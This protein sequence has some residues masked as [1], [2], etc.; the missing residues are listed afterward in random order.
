VTSGYT[1]SSPVTV[2]QVS[3]PISVKRSIV[4][5]RSPK[6]NL[7][8]NEK[9]S[10]AWDQFKEALETN[11]ST[12]QE[13]EI[14][15]SLDKGLSIASITKSLASDGYIS[16]EIR[17]VFDIYMAVI[18]FGEANGDSIIIKKSHSSLPILITSLI[19]ELKK[20]AVLQ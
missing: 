11:F 1:Y 20:Q 14:I 2:T 6:T 5:Y 9:T 15:P 19:N 18:E 4:L 16:G 7:V 10:M 17:W 3:S 13:K 8:T 12:V